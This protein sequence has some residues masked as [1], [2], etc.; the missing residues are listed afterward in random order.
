MCLRRVPI[1]S[2]TRKRHKWKPRHRV[3][4][5]RGHVL[6]RRFYRV[7]GSGLAVGRH[8]PNG[9]LVYS[10]NDKMLHELRGACCGPGHG[11][12]FVL[13]DFNLCLL[14]MPT[15]WIR[16]IMF[17]YLAQLVGSW[18]NRRFPV[19]PPAKEHDRFSMGLLLAWTC[20]TTRVHEI[21]ES[22]CSWYSSLTHILW[23]TRVRIR[24]AFG[25]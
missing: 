21:I 7:W 14:S 17:H 15:S 13:C 20:S 23:R 16:R 24:M 5:D 3:A 11:D 18:K 22:S 8:A 9:V 10:P 4:L 12:R 2:R 25:T 6:P 19:A 1:R